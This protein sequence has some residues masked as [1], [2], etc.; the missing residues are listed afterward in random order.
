MGRSDA[1]TIGVRLLKI[2]VVYLVGGLMLGLLMGIS[3]NFT[4]VSVH[5]HILL[6]GW[7]SMAVAGIIYLLMPGSTGGRLAVS[8]FWGH[9]VG[10]PVM[11]ASLALKESGRNGMDAI[12]GAS[13]TL[14]LISLVLFA[15]NL[16]R[17]DGRP[18]RPPG[19]AAAVNL[20]ATDPELPR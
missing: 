4:L 12:I 16:F 17:S 15:V 20:S 18:G 1:V 6:L 5:G 19:P 7:L 11:M 9:N 2:S 14:V 13:S 10:L 3:G 8:H